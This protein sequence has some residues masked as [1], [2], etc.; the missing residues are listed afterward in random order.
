[1]KIYKYTYKIHKDT[2][3]IYKKIKLYPNKFENS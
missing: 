1:M 2:P 3:N